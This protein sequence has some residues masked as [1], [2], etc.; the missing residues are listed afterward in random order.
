MNQPL[1]GGCE[2]ARERLW[3]E[4]DGDFYWVVDQTGGSWERIT[5]T[6]TLELAGTLSHRLRISG[7]IAKFVDGQRYPVLSPWTGTVHLTAMTD[8][9][10]FAFMEEAKHWRHL[11]LY[12]TDDINRM[13]DETRGSSALALTGS[14]EGVFLPSGS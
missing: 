5:G 11:C 3:I 10:A 8:L 1:L 14:M 4:Q 13:W 9:P 7:T 6:W 12:E 2:D